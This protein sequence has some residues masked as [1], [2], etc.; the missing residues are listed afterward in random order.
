MT[1]VFH[2]INRCIVVEFYKQ[3]AA[4]F[5]LIFLILFGF[6]KSGE[7]IAIGSFL[8]ATPSALYYL[9]ILW[10]VYLIKVILFIIPA[11]NKEDNH[12]MEVFCLLPMKLKINTVTLA[13]VQLL[14]PI[15]AYALF[16]ISLAFPHAFYISI[17]SL[18]L[19]L[20]IFISVIS[21]FFY[22]KL[23]ALPHEKVTFQIRVFNKITIPS[24]LFFIEHMLR[25]EIVLL[26]LSK[27][28][29]CALLI[30]TSI[31]YTTDQFDLRLLTIGVLLAFVGNVAIVHKYVWFRHYQMA[32]LKNL[33]LPLFTRLSSQ[34][35]TFTVLLI[36]EFLVLSRHYP[37]EPHFLDITGIVLFG[38]S[39]TLLMYAL[40]LIKQAELSD[41]MIVMFWIVVVTTFLILFSIHPLILAL[42]YLFISIPTIYIRHYKFEYVE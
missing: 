37:L 18:A 32:F 7:H 10:L 24:F 11:I 31:L 26:L 12:F 20:C 17:F 21:Y 28:Y 5:G 6:I 25:K 13:S 15:I 1:S 29:V 4:F 30:G 41:F 8:V 16:L 40:L 35:I 36:P 27:F 22:A 39:L 19:S 38:I 23:N 34:V 14:M 33:P 3:N 2:I 9:Y 42:L